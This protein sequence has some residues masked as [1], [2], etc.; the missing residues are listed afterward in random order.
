[1]ASV[2]TA[3]TRCP[4]LKFF[5][6]AP[7]LPYH[8]IGFLALFAVGALSFF[9]IMKNLTYVVAGGVMIWYVQVFVGIA[10]CKWQ[11]R[12]FQARLLEM[13]YRW[14]REG[15]GEYLWACYARMVAASVT[16]AD[17]D[18]SGSR[19]NWRSRNSWSGAC[20]TSQPA[21]ANRGGQTKY[22]AVATGARLRA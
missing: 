5:D 18:M 14:L 10:L 11:K 19:M 15:V 8:C 9:G 12:D 21:S 22:E 2:T 6:V 1:M 7:R 17:Y 13:K 16:D 3:C 4:L 20:S